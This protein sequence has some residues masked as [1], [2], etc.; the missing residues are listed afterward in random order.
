M[1]H[2]TLPGGP[3]HGCV[4]AP[5]SKSHAHRLLICGALGKAPVSL[6]C[7]DISKDIAATAR[8]LDALC[9]AVTVNDGVL[10]VVPAARR[11]K[12]DLFC[13]ESGATLRFLLPVCGALGAEAVF[14]RE[15]RLPHRPLAP[16]DA[17][18]RGHGMHLEA[19]GD[20]LYC[21]GRLQS[22]LFEIPGNVSSQF[23]SGL[24]FALPLLDG[25]STLR[26]TGRV[27]SAAYIAM[28]EQALA[29][30][31]IRFVRSGSEYTVFGAQQYTAAETA[32]EGDYSNGA[33]FLCMG[34]LSERGIRVKNLPAETRQGDRA[35]VD[36]LRRFGA[37]VRV[38]DDEIF[39]RGGT[40]HG[41][42]ID[43]API[44]DLIPVLS[45]V[46]AAAQG[47]SRI[48]N[49]G[50]LRL[51]ESDR[52]RATAEMLTALGGTVTELPDG[53]VI[54][55]GVLQGGTVPSY[56]DHRMAMSA[57]VAACA[58]R[59]PVTVLDPACTDKSF[60]RFWDIFS[61][62]EGER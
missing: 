54:R 1:T 55:G 38:K 28:T 25:E 50:R 61:Q 41:C 30:S 45:V 7:D 2:I 35:V 56:N 6:R 29:Q 18:L 49:A 23:I 19:Q 10:Q 51:K 24:L 62:L 5:A 12:K 31:G 40:L 60:P 13:G 11:G 16:L 42:E 47:E 22:G 15:G 59:R 37:Q 34:A 48:M 58:C 3:R 21:C 9:A 20:A 52:L 43:A 32:V 27:E 46:A 14:H 53:L 39:V 57:A 33:F 4:R 8:C 36:I 26:I 17:V 44:P